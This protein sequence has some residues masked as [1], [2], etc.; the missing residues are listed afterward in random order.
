MVL[1]DLTV[2]NVDRKPSYTVNPLKVVVAD[3]NGKLHLADLNALGMANSAKLQLNRLKPGAN[4]SG[5]VLASI[6]KRRTVKRIR[7]EVGV[8]GPPLEIAV[9]R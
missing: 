5:K 7:Y 3:N 4:E 8:L 1:A 6:P 9:T 2:K